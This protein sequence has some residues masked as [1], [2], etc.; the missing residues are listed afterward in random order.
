M[1]AISKI[2]HNSNAKLIIPV[3]LIVALVFGFFFSLQFLLNNPTPL[4]VVESGS[5]CIPY[6]YRD[7]CDG[8]LSLTHTFNGTL[9]KGDIIIVQGV[10]PRDLNTDYPNS[11]IIVYKKPDNVLDTP[12]VHRIVSSYELNGTLYFETKGDGNEP[13]WPQTPTADVY[14][15]KWLYN[16]GQGVPA[17]LVEGKVI[18]RIPYLGWITLILKEYTWGVPLIVGLILL[19][20][21]IEFLMPLAKL[22]AKQSA[23]SIDLTI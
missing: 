6:G 2:R 14:D 4:R 18:L 23:N 7:A 12:V 3:V 11:N 13:T 9:H 16:T 20:V 5:M 19:L 15:S 8:W 10:N 17:E 21:I 22:K 1:G